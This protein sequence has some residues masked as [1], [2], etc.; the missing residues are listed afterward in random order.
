AP[1]SADKPNLR[2]GVREVRYALK[3]GLLAPPAVKTVKEMHAVLADSDWLQV[4]TFRLEGEGPWDGQ[5]R[6]QLK[7][8]AQNSLAAPPRGFLL[9]ARVNGWSFHHK[10]DVLSPEPEGK[11]LQLVLRDDPTDP[12]R[13]LLGELPLRPN[14]P[15]EIY[16]FVRNPS[17]QDKKGVVV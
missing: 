3:V 10:I 9:Q 4:E 12:T 15:Q 14:R 5:V 7:P 8:D 16:V 17:D 13:S 2:E 1:A 11:R 6:I